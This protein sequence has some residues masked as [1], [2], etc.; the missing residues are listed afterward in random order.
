MASQ[1]DLP[2]TSLAKRIIER[3]EKEGLLD[4]SRVDKFVDS[5]ATGKLREGDWKLA[6]EAVSKTQKK[7]SK[8]R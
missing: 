6:L 5:L 8:K 1:P 3:L 4:V 2:A 7:S